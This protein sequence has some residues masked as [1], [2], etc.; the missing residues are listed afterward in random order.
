MSCSLP[1]EILDFI[2]DQLH[3]EPTTLKACC[4]VSKSWIPRTRRHLFARVDFGGRAIPIESWM[5]IFPDPSNSPAHHTRSL[6]ICSLPVLVTTT[7]ADVASCVRTFRNVV[8]LRF[9]H[10]TWTGQQN[11]LTPFYGFSHTVR[12]LRL[13]STSFEVFNLVC[14][15]PLLENLAL[16]SLGS[17][18]GAAGWNAPSTSPELT[19]SLSLSMMMGE[20]RPAIL[21][22]LDFPDGLRFTKITVSRLGE[23]DFEPMM[24]LVSKCSGTLECL[25]ISSFTISAFPSASLVGRYL[26]AKNRDAQGVSP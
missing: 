17:E 13:T 10:L 26:T 19:G 3:N 9:K 14:S 24:D 12:S 18:V 25:T 4:V 21:R 23:S 2:I 1:P 6:S 20:I 7:N 11:P 15:F 8:R 16:V 5:K 22:L